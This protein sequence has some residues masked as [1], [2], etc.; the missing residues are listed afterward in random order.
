M[1]GKD[2]CLLTGMPKT[3]YVYQEIKRLKGGKGSYASVNDVIPLL[4]NQARNLG[5]DAVIT[6]D[7]SGLGLGLSF[8][9]DAW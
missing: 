4:V 2:V 7:H 8:G 1:L 9:F 3:E 6:M 5:A